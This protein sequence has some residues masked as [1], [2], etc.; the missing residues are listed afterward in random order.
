MMLELQ[1]AV[2]CWGFVL[3]RLEAVPVVLLE[4]V[5]P[6]PVPAENRRPPRTQVTAVG[7]AGGF[8]VAAVADAGAAA[9]AGAASG[10][11]AAVADAAV[12]AAAAAGAGF[13]IVA[14]PGVG[15][16]GVGNH[17]HKND[18]SNELRSTNDFFRATGSQKGLRS[19]TS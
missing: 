13:V 11:D 3:L 17:A 2:E 9:V 7:G 1:V 16:T 4:A 19:Q 6:V 12:A 5:V 15:G 10:A 14:V 8:V 18:Q